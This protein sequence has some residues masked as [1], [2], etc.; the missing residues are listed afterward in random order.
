MSYSHLHP[1]R[2]TLNQIIIII[3]IP[4]Q[5]KPAIHKALDWQTRL[6]DSLNHSLHTSLGLHHSHQQSIVLD[7]LIQTPLQKITIYCT[8][9]DPN[10]VFKLWS[11]LY[12]L[13]QLLDLAPRKVSPY[14]LNISNVSLCILCLFPFFLSSSSL[15]LLYIIPLKSCKSS[16]SILK[17]SPCQ[18]SL[19]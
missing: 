13:D 7:G 4:V 2:K 3:Q 19:S 17:L 1:L 18:S 11:W 9:L 12:R 14:S 6:N 8:L 10:E 15:L 16:F 5:L